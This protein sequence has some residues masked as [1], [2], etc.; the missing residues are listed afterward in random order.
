MTFITGDTHGQFSRIK[1]FCDKM[2]GSL[3]QENDIMII[4]GDAGINYWSCHEY[5]KWKD[6]KLKDK[7][8]KLPITLFS[9]HGNHEMRPSSIETYETKQWHGGTVYYEEK[10]PNLLF[11]K[12]G[13]VY[14]IE[15]K[16]VL[17]IGGAYSVDKHYRLIRDLN[18]FSDEQPSDEIK[19]D[20]L[21]TINK[22]NGKFDA[23]LTHTAP[24][25]YE[26][27]EWFLQGLD[28]STVDKS[29][30]EWLDEIYDKIKCKYWYCGHYHGSKIID[31]GDHKIRFMFEDIDEFFK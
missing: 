20:V 13:E 25:R 2:N 22:H 5:D 15:G 11:A 18:W 14:D 26:P 3:S 17:V 12:D 16:K 27:I 10:Y 1:E 7:L 31:A 9:I 30:E 6:K 4:L 23:V 28:Q 29:T 21:K 8:V 24:L 19:A